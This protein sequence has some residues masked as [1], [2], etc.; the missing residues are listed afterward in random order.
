MKLLRNGPGG[1]IRVYVGEPRRM[2]LSPQGSRAKSWTGRSAPE[3]ENDVDRM[4]I[5][6]FLHFAQIG[7]I[8]VKQ[9]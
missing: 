3:R 6:V 9:I 4:M 1:G 5:F 8:E 7:R 2:I